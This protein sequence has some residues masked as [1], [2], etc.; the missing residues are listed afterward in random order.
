MPVLISIS[1][2]PVR[3]RLEENRVANEVSVRQDGMEFDPER[4]W[5]WISSFSLRSNDATHLARICR[6]T[7][8]CVEEPRKRCRPLLEDSRIRLKKRNVA[9]DIRDQNERVIP[10]K[11]VVYV[12][13][14]RDH[15][16]RCET[17]VREGTGKRTYMETQSPSSLMNR[18]LQPISLT[19]ST[20]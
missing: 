18:W 6:Y 8:L 12:Y 20:C 14:L 16:R 7:G 10:P 17:L 2:N 3:M 13:S 5:N 4:M 11:N 15:G 1:S 9:P 19:A